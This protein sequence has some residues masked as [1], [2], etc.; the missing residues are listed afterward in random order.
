MGGSAG[1]ANCFWILPTS[2]VQECQF[3]KV[4]T[5]TAGTLGRLS[6]R[7]FVAAGDLCL[8]HSL[9]AHLSLLPASSH[10]YA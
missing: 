7:G 8:Q 2:P 6:G 9:A 3:A 1:S 10:M 4:S 5:T